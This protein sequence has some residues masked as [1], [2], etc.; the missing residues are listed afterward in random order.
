MKRPRVLRLEFIGYRLPQHEQ[1]DW[2]VLFTSV[3]GFFDIV[4]GCVD[5]R[6]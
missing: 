2:T 4:I 6:I 5:I 3:F 1:N